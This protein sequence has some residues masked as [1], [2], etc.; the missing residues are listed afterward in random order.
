[1]ASGGQLLEARLLSPQQAPPQLVLDF[2]SFKLY[3]EIYLE[4]NFE[5]R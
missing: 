1:M 5:A 3:V 4:Q 2:R